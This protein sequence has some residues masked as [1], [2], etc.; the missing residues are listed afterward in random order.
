M[1]THS[2]PDYI[3]LTFRSTLLCRDIEDWCED[4]VLCCRSILCVVTGLCF[5]CYQPT[6]LVSTRCFNK[7][8]WYIHTTIRIGIS[9]QE[10]VVII[11]WAMMDQKGL[12]SFDHGFSVFITGIAC[13]LIYTQY[14]YFFPNFSLPHSIAPRS[15]YGYAFMENWKS[16]KD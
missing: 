5:C 14:L 4:C 3:A 8:E 6:V 2:S 9:M 15:K 7:A 10:W 12:F 1:F 11:L 13:F 16:Y